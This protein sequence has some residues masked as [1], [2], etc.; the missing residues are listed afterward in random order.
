MK[1]RTRVGAI[2]INRA[3]TQK[4]SLTHVATNQNITN[5]YTSIEPELLAN[6]VVHDSAKNVKRRRLSAT[7]CKAHIPTHPHVSPH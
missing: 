5:L 6:I 2:L 7:Y 4:Y 1:N 3:H